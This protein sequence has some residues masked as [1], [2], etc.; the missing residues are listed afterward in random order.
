MGT[1]ANE[2]V[3]QQFAEFTNLREAGAPFGA[4]TSLGEIYRSLPAFSSAMR[5]HW[6]HEIENAGFTEADLDAVHAGVF[7]AGKRILRILSNGESWDSDEIILVLTLREEIGLI[8]DMWPVLTG[9][10]LDYS[11]DEVDAAILSLASGRKNRRLL[12][13][14]LATIA[15]N[16]D[17]PVPDP[18]FSY[19]RQQLGTQI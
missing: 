7:A 17:P 18:F 6:L 14:A 3:L 4:A 12:Q 10:S 8:V 5:A 15:S 13:G 11:C 19:V 9:S 1:F 2:R 16:T